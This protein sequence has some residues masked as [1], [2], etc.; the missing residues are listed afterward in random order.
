M[1]AK[2]CYHHKPFY[3]RKGKPAR[4]PNYGENEFNIWNSMWALPL[5]RKTISRMFQI[6]RLYLTISLIVLSVQF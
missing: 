6:Y 4:Y 2:I 3:P 1:G 5:K